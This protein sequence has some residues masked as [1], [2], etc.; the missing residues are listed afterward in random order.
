MPSR[1]ILHSKRKIN[2]MWDCFRQMP[3]EKGDGANAGTFAVVGFLQTANR[4]P[5][6]YLVVSNI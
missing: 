5:V 4:K 6:I 2:E 1:T 3:A